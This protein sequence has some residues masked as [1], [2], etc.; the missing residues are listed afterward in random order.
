M[1]VYTAIV[2]SY[3]SGGSLLYLRQFI[4]ALQRKDYPA[5]CYL[6]RNARLSVKNNRLYRHILKDPSSSPPWLKVKAIKYFYHLIKYFSNALILKPEKQL[7]IVH[8]LFPFYLTDWIMVHRLKKRGI[9]VVLTVHNVFDH[10]LYLRG[11]IDK[12]LHK[13][14]YKNADLLF[15]HSDSL[16]NELIDFCPMDHRKIK[17]V[18]HGY[19]EMPESSIDVI[20]LKRKYSVPLDKKILLFFGSMRNNKGLDILLS[21]FQELKHEFFLFIVGDAV[22]VNHLSRKYYENIIVNRGLI[23]SICWIKRHIQD[24]EIPNVFRIPDAVILPY[25]K[26]FHAQSGILQL[27]VYYEKPC[28]VS[29]VGAIAASVRDYNLGEVVGA[30]DPIALKKGIMSIFN[31]VDSNFNFDFKK[32]KEDNNWDKTA[33][34]VISAYKEII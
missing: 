19:F 5:I 7:R 14:L 15:V 4:D 12:I 32:Y 13:K 27:A 18:P 30:E 21:A 3:G 31:K 34:K 9:K 28:V 16:R 29:D 23:E 8:L 26:S 17:V 24:D 10:Y 25:K 20:T 11:K 33:D 6:P 22:G 1:K 2:S